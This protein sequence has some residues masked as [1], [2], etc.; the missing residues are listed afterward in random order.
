MLGLHEGSVVGMATGYAMARGEPAFVN[1]HTAPGLGNAV[2]AIANARDCRAPLVVVVGQQDRRQLAFE[3]FLTGRALERLAGEYPVWTHPADPRP[4]RPRRDR[5]RLPRGERGAAARRWWWCRWATGTSRPTSWR[6]GSP[7]RI[8]RPRSVAPEDVA[9]LAELI[10]RRPIARASWSAP[11]PTAA[12]AGTPW[13]RLAERLRCPVWQEPF[14][15]PRRL[16]AGP[17]AVRRPPAAGAGGAMRETLAPHDLVVAI[18]TGA[19]RLYLFD[20][21]ESAGAAGHA[22]RR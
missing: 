21:P 3:P 1:L 22:R 20:E 14:S 10:A 7:A 15:A 8:L 9:E 13:S 5:P 12:R 18:G 2:N 4:G 16:P 17:P 11:A 6:A 19:F